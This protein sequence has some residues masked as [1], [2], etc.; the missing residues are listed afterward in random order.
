LDGVLGR[1]A[2]RDLKRGEPFGWDMI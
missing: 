1:V 2:K